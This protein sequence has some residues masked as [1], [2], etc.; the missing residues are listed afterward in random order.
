MS[1]VCVYE[2]NPFTSFTGLLLSSAL[3]DAYVPPVISRYVGVYALSSAV[4]QLE[5]G[6]ALETLTQGVELPCPKRFFAISLM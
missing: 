5:K 6:V 1:I 4:Q 2:L 3:T